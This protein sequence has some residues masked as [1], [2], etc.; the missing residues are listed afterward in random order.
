MAGQHDV[1]AEWAAEEIPD[2][3][4]LFMAVHRGHFESNGTVAPAAFRNHG[5]GMSTNW[6]KYS[7]PDETRQRMKKPADNAVVVM[8]VGTVRAIPGQRVVHSPLLS[9][10]AHTDVQGNKSRDPEV[11]VKL[12]RASEIIIPLEEH[13]AR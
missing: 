12:R 5:D 4:D 11:R 6:S 2:M 7:S 3:D 9:N 1:T 8:N 13:G 10:R